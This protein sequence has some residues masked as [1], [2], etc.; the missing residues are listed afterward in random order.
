MAPELLG[1]GKCRKSDSLP[2]KEVLALLDSRSRNDSKSL[3]W[4]PLSPAFPDLDSKICSGLATIAN[5]ASRKC[6]NFG[7]FPWVNDR[8]LIRLL[9]GVANT[10]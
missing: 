9:E 8:N 3:F 6:Y 10:R 7:A 2:H 4:P 1:A 5:S